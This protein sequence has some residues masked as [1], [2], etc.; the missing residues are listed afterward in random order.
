V[1]SHK[2]QELCEDLRLVRDGVEI[3]KDVL[4]KE[5][6]AAVVLEARLS[7]QPLLVVRAHKAKSRVLSLSLYDLAIS[8]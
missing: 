2:L 5:A 1:A 8:P 4:P 7:D 3:A 6:L